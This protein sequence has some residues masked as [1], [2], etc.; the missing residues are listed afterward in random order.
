MNLLNAKCRRQLESAN[1]NVYAT[2]SMHPDRT[3]ILHD[4]LHLTQGEWEIYEDGQRYV[5]HAG[6]TLFLS[7]GKHHYSKTRCAAETRCMYLHITSDAHDNLNPEHA[8]YIPTFIKREQADLSHHFDQL[9]H[10]HYSQINEKEMRV[11]AM[12]DLLLCD[13]NMMVVSESA[14]PTTPNWYPANEVL[15]LILARLNHNYS[16]EE[17]ASELGIGMRSLRYLFTKNIGCS[18]YRYQLNVKLDIARQLMLSEPGH[19]LSDIASMFG[20]YDEFH[21]SHAFKSRFDSSPKLQ[22]MLEKNF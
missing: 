1:Y 15:R 2:P 12:I 3:L 20:F 6:D 14:Q 22:K 4:A 11:A 17:M 21:L 13:M 10:L 5:M 16:V 7:A 8:L 9:I 18:P 19:T